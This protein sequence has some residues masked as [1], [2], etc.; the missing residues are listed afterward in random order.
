MQKGRQYIYIWKRVEKAG[1]G[2]SNLRKF[3]GI[4]GGNVQSIVITGGI[5]S[6]ICCYRISSKS[7]LTTT[8]FHLRQLE[9]VINFHLIMFI[10][11]H[12][13][14]DCKHDLKLKQI[15]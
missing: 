1:L 4:N 11:V 12:T 2:E 3:A 14:I 7:N 15:E 10:H 9:T 5:Q 13:L 6:V 8:R